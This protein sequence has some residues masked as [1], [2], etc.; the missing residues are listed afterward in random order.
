M[1]TAKDCFLSALERA[2]SENADWEDKD[3]PAIKVDDIDEIVW[4]QVQNGTWADEAFS[5]V[6]VTKDR[7]R[8]LVRG[9]CDT[10]GWSCLGNKWEMRDADANDPTYPVMPEL[11]S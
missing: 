2:T 1:I 3:A 10:T 9:Q 6:V 11:P 7:R 8:L 4:C 5:A